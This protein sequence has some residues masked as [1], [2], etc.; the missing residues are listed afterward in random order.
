MVEAAF[1]ERGP[2]YVKWAAEMAAGLQTGVPW[3]MCRQNDAPDPVV[4]K[5]IIYNHLRK[6]MNTYNSCMCMQINACNG[7]KCGQT[8]VGPN[9]PNKPSIWTEN[10]TS[11][12][13]TKIFAL[14][15][16]KN[17]IQHANRPESNFNFL[18]FK[19]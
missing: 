1:K 3:V 4:I 9:S 17:K 8:F 6:N 5:L 10:W 14:I 12:Y 7:M 15:S 16:K 11:Q 2:P 19:T 13:V 18:I